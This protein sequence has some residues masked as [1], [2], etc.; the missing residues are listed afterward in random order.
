MLFI[1]PLSISDLA[2][3]ERMEVFA[4]DLAAQL[5][6]DPKEGMFFRVAIEPDPERSEFRVVTERIQHGLTDRSFLVISSSMAAI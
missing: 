3:R 5:P 1:A 2:K 6:S 4:S